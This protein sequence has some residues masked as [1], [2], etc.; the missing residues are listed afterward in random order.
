MDY[1]PIL[2]AVVGVQSAK[3]LKDNLKIDKKPSNKSMIKKSINTMVG[4]GLIN[5]TSSMI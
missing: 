5:A 2:G 1:K 4:I 3:L